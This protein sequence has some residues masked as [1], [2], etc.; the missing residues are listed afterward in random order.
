MAKERTSKPWVPLALTVVIWLQAGLAA[1]VGLASILVISGFAHTEVD[2]RRL[3][4][5][6]LAFALILVLVVIPQFRQQ[7][8][9]LFVP[10]AWTAFHFGDSLYELLALGDTNFVPPVILELLFLVIY[11]A[12]YRA[13]AKG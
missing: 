3:G 13:L 10:L 7:H 12:F 8:R 11:L 2:G 5:G 6:F 1:F 9:L 4:V